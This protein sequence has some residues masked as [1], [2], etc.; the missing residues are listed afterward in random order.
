MPNPIKKARKIEQN[1]YRLWHDYGRK[2][3]TTVTT[4]DYGGP[5]AAD[6][7][8]AAAPASGQKPERLCTIE[9]H[10]IDRPPIGPRWPPVPPAGRSLGRWAGPS[11]ADRRPVRALCGASS[12]RRPGLLCGSAARRGRAPDRRAPGPRSSGSRCASVGRYDGQT[13]GEGQKRPALAF[14]GAGWCLY[15]PGWK[16]RSEGRKMAFTAVSCFR[17]LLGGHRWP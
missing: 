5:W 15:I 6:P 9:L 11:P 7:A 12:D 3:A 2:S 17:L 1:D 16:N 4:I 8:P 13:Y 10:A 14:F